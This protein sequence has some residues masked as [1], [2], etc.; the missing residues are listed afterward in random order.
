MQQDLDDGAASGRELEEHP[1]E[2][3]QCSRIRTSRI[4]MVT[5]TTAGTRRLS[6][7]TRGDAQSTFSR[8][9]KQEKDALHFP[10]ACYAAHEL[11]TARDRPARESDAHVDARAVHRQLR[12]IPQSGLYAKVRRPRLSSAQAALPERRH[13]LCRPRST[14]DRPEHVRAARRSASD[15][16]SA[17]CTTLANVVNLRDSAERLNSLTGVSSLADKRAPSSDNSCPRG[18]CRR[19][20]AI[21]RTP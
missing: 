9:I 17:Q 21:S 15:M 6:G 14:R 7:R 10:S 11:S 20:T 1:D 16:C 19:L 8:Q 3:E 12:A 13:A 18:F 5:Q 4:R 2:Y